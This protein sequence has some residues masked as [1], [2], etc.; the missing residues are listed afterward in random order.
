MR[1]AKA[2]TAI[3]WLSIIT[4]SNLS[5]K[6]KRNFFHAVVV[7]ILLYGCTT[8]TL[9]KRREKKLNGSYTRMLWAILNKS[10]KQ[11]SRKEQLYGHQPPISKTIQIRQTRHVGHS[12][13]SKDEHTS[14]ILL[15]T[16]HLDAQVLDN[17]QELEV[18]QLCTDT[19]CSLE[20]QAEAMD[21][22]DEWRERQ[23]ERDRVREIRSN[24]TTW[25]W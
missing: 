12:W 5:E 3:D 9:I 2:W 23:R 8:W 20:D 24:S 14:N 4:K 15:E 7:L 19:G 6:I 16:H 11:H 21:Y 25:G 13:R 1:L 10:W 22:I 18:Q 17:Q